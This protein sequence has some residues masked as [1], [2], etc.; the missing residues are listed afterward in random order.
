MLP[1]AVVELRTRPA[2]KV[3][4]PCSAEPAALAC[5]SRAVLTWPAALTFNRAPI[6]AEPVALRARKT[7]TSDG[8]EAVSFGDEEDVVQGAFGF[9]LLHR[10]AGV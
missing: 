10:E 6:S 2:I 9:G 3:G 7:R 1:T 5:E 8:S 4:A